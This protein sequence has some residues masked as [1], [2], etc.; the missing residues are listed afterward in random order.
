MKT[1][2]STRKHFRFTKKH[3]KSGQ[4]TL[5][6]NHPSIWLQSCNDIGLQRIPRWESTRKHFHFTKKHLK[7][8]KKLFL[9]IILRWLLPT[10]T[11]VWV[12]E[13]HGRVLE[14]TFVLTKKH[15]KSG[16][17]K[18]LPANHPDLATSYN[19]IGGVYDQHGRVLESTFALRKKHLK[20]VKKLFLQIILIVGYFLQQHRYGVCNRWETTRKHF[21]F[22]K[23]HLKSGQ[24]NSSCKSSFVG[25]FLQQHRCGVLQ[26]GRVLESTFVLRKST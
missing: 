11:S 6:A 14:S 19:N 9:Q 3:L 18:T 7:S 24:K 16:R 23:K 5:P 15:L 17:R 22:T 20:S 1:W 2:E 26:H 8:F 10:T 25:Y 12:Y 4:K 21:H 13:E